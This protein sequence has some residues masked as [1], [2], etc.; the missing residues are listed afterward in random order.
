MCATRTKGTNTNKG[1]TRTKGTQ[2]IIAI[3]SCVLA[4]RKPVE[5]RK[6]L[7]LGNLSLEPCG[8]P[9]PPGKA[10]PAARSESCVA[11]GRPTLRS[12]DSQ[13][14]GRVIEPRNLKTRGAFVVDISGGRVRRCYTWS[15]RTR[16]VLPGSKSTGNGHQ[17]SP[18]TWEAPTSPSQFRIGRPDTKLPGPRWDAPDRGERITGETMVSAREGNEADRDGRRGFGASHSTDEPGERSRW[19]PGREGDAG[20]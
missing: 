2:L 18:G 6:R 12:V 13:V 7:E 15:R 14:Q 16:L 19:T 20:S 10:G 8:Y 9:I 3:I 17:G 1:D 4:P 5:R 11:V